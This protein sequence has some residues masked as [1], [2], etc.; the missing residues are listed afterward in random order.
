MISLVKRTKTNFEHLYC[1]QMSSA[2][3]SQVKMIPK[4]ATSFE[5]L[6]FSMVDGAAARTQTCLME[7]ANALNQYTQIIL[8]NFFTCMGDRII[9]SS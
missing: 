9:I 7:T 8:Q 5:Y 3:S 4:Y 6:A 2:L 1:L